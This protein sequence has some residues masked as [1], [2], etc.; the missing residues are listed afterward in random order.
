MRP[1]MLPEDVRFTGVS[2]ILLGPTFAT[3]LSIV[4]RTWGGFLVGFGVLLGGVGAFL[5]S[6]DTRRLRAGVAG[7]T[8][9]AF[10]S[11]LV[12]NIQLRSDFLWYIGLLFAAAI[13]LA[14]ILFH[15]ES[16]E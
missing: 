3:W 5:W 6:A 15:L 13:A 16:R 7:G 12:S 11:F 10:G 9:F 14:W 8:V 4:F 1:P 2:P